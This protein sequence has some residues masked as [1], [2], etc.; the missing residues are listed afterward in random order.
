MTSGNRDLAF[1]V[2][3]GLEWTII[4]HQVETQYPELPELIQ[5][6]LNVEHHVGQGESWDEQ[7]RFTVQKAKA[8]TIGN[9]SQT[10]PGWNVVLTIVAASSPPFLADLPHHVSFLKK[11]GGGIQLQLADDTLGYIGVAMPQCRIVLGSF[12]ELS[13]IHIS[14]PTRPY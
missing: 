13:L 8:R 10:Q 6:A 3:Q 1:A 9:G 5:R 11:W 4:K 7:F 12:I 2:E 14:Q